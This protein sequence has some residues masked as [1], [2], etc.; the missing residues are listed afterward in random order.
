[1]TPVARGIAGDLRASLDRLWGTLSIAILSSDCN[2]VLADA[3]DGH[4]KHGSS[5]D[6]LLG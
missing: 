6:V 4:P 5:V 3:T 1:M 2:P